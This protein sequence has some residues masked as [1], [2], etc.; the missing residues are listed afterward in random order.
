MKPNQ[1][2]AGVTDIY[3]QRVSDAPKKAE[4]ARAN[5]R[6]SQKRVVRV[7]KDAV[8]D[9]VT[10]EIANERGKYGKMIEN[11]EKRGSLVSPFWV[12]LCSAKCSISRKEAHLWFTKRDQSYVLAGKT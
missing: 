11:H 5:G 8:C 1:S 9:V 7:A 4:I 12:M 3:E 2:G 6:A 10:N